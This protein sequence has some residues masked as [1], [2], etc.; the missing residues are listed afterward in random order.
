[1]GDHPLAAPRHASEIAGSPR[2]FRWVQQRLFCPQNFVVGVSGDFR[3]GISRVAGAPVPRLA[4][5][6]RIARAAPVAYAADEAGAGREDVNQTNIRM[7]TRAASRRRTRRLLRSQV[8]ICRGSAHVAAG[9]AGA[10]RFGFGTGREHLGREHQAPKTFPRARR[11]RERQCGGSLMRAVID[12]WHG[13]VT[14]RRQARADNEVNSFGV[15]VEIRR[16]SSASSSHTPWTIRPLVRLYLP[17]PGG[18]AEQVPVSRLTSPENRDLVR[19]TERVRQGASHAGGDGLPWTRYG[20][21]TL[22]G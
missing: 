12:R 13:A 3:N 5:C 16:R 17:A 6:S 14:A 10:E 7:G 1:M 15:P 9:A 2:A 22:E 18:H 11:S 4:P 19:G 8:A 20:G 21:R